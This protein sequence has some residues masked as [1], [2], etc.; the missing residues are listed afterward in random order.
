VSTFQHNT[1]KKSDRKRL[2]WGPPRDA[3]QMVEQLDD[4]ACRGFLFASEHAIG[5]V[6]GF[7]HTYFLRR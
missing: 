6:G 7:P 5:L 1:E 2:Q 3:A 4:G